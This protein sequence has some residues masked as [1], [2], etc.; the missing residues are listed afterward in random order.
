LHRAWAVARVAIFAVV[1]TVFM[2][3]FHEIGHTLVARALGDPTAHFVLVQT[4]K[5]STCLGCNLY[6]SAR[7]S[8]VANII[9][10]FG[11]VLFTQILCWSAVLLMAFSDRRVFPS[12][13]LWTVIAITWLGDLVF[14]LLQGLSTRVPLHL[15]RGPEMSY[16]DY[17]AVA[18]F[19]RDATGISATTWKLVL[20]LATL[21][22]SLVIALALG[23][24]VRRR[25]QSLRG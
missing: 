2:V 11:G 13:M 5:T 3:N 6:D 12:R 24:A 15:A 17:T 19:A 16:T 8:D 14:Q 25:R 1:F 10:N 21:V 18:W 9:V 20:L 22:Y 7:L 4:S 23:W